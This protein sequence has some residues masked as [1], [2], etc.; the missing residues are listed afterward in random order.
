MIYLDNA[1]TSF[2]KPPEVIRA[3]SGAME[4]IGANPGRS[5]HRLSLAAGRVVWNC[6]EELARML[7]V[8]NPENIVF[9]CNCTDALNL[10]IYGSVSPG[11]H[12]VTTMLEHNS[13]LRPINGM[14]HRGEITWTLL[15]PDPSGVVTAEQVAAVITPLTRLVVIN[16][17]SNV[18][19]LAQPVADI[20]R[21]TRRA[22]VLLLV[23][24]AQSL[25][26]LPV[27]PLEMGADMVAFP[28]HKGLLGP[29]GTGALWIRSGLDLTPLKEGGTGSSSESMLQP[30][31]MP[32]ALE[33]GTLNMAGIAGLM[34]GTRY[35]RIRRQE[36][37]EHEKSL[38]DAMWEGL[39]NIHGVSV[40]T[41][42]PPDVGVVSF[43]VGAFT[44]GE[45]ANKLDTRFEI[46]TRG[47]LHCAPAIHTHLGTLDRGAVRASVGHFNT[48]SDVD[49]LLAAV[50][51]IAR[52]VS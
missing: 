34:V 3:V 31:E 24:A 19:G 42:R 10:G 5:G 14:V 13:V 49:A 36:I 15:A 6:R 41:G 39:R 16:H 28:G 33:S 23:D 17:A 25:G 8:P 48:K 46:A 20:A 21:V 9:G 1:A 32:E 37:Y 43:N 52:E 27:R 44:S 11:D 29:Y 35:V 7:D 50:S 51:E 18:V 26:V 4:K 22:G 12:V 47:G 30:D 45:V 2:P 40:L 38:S